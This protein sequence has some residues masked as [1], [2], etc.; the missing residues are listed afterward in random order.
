M[1]REINFYYFENGKSPIEEFLDNLSNE[2][3]KKVFFVFDLVEQLEKIPQ[4]FLKKLK[5]TDNLWEIRVKAKSNIRFLGFF[6]DNQIIILT[7]AFI[8]KRQKIEKKKL[9]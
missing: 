8:K 3:V 4:K 5:G 6:H 9:K 2:D 7:H 1:F